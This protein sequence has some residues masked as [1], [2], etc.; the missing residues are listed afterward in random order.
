MSERRKGRNP[1]VERRLDRMLAVEGVDRMR[2]GARLITLSFAAIG[3]LLVLLTGWPDALYYWA[4]LL[5]FIGSV[6][7][8]YHAVRRLPEA[9][10]PEYAFPV[11]NFSLLTFVLVVPNP[12]SEFAAYEF[13]PSLMMRFG[14]VLYIFL[15]LSTLALSFSPRSVLWGG[16]VA[17]A[18][19]SLGRLWVVTR[20]GV[21]IFA[22]AEGGYEPENAAATFLE[23]T[24]PRY[25][26]P[27]VWVQEVVLI[28]MISAILAQV[29]RGSRRLLVRRASE[30][31]RGA[32]LARYLPAQMAERMAASDRPFF[33]DREAE[34]VVLFTDIVGFTRL[35]ESH[36]PRETVALL[37]DIHRI[38]GDEVFRADGVLDKFIGDG[39][40]A[41]FGI[42]RPDTREA[43]ALS[44]VEGI[45]ARMAEFNRARAARGDD[46]IRLSLGLHRGAVTVGDVGGAGRLEMAVLGDAVN[47]ASRLEALTRQLDCAALASDT[48]IS[49]AG[50]PPPGWSRQGEIA[51]RGREEQV[52][53][54]RREANADDPA[55]SLTR[56]SAPAAPPA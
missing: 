30:E 23:A 34:A 39:A 27:G 14:N 32:N 4:L 17:V 35:A 40:M 1:D 55:G 8:Q 38:V 41:T 48:V 36:G 6:W 54:W 46:P 20:P 15:I 5:V 53:A 21:E 44:C 7:L 31:R 11:V 18:T 42:A 13:A 16:L 2:T 28:L 19:W 22:P 50:G 9:D 26:D 25:V 10:W 12:M 47:V 51:L 43:R 24:H 49:G 37:R 52:V 56:A 45:L 33:E 3:P 29:V